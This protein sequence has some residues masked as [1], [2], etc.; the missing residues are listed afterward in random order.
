VGHRDVQTPRSSPAPIWSVTQYF[1][2]VT[3]RPATKDYNRELTKCRQ[4]HQVIL[5]HRLQGFSRFAPGSQTAY[6]HECVE[7]FFP[8]QVRHPGAGRFARSSAVEVNVLILGQ[9]LD[10]FLQIVGFD[11]N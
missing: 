2:G 3:E 9:V 4:L 6:D 8:Q 7:S 5:G 1:I 10:L 11:A